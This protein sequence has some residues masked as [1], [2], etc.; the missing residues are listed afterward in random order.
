MNIQK[1]VGEN[2]RFIRQKRGLTL[3]A[4]AGKAKT[5]FSH[6]SDI[7]RGIKAPTIITIAKL[8]KVL[9]VTPAILMTPDAYKQIE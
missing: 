6:I 7:E 5:S 4:L 8:A 1:I 3:E 9:Q 2:I